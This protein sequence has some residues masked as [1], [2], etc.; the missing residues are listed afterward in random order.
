MTLGAAKQE[1]QWFTA[2]YVT[3][4]LLQNAEQ[5]KPTQ[6][7]VTAYLKEVS[8]T[9]FSSGEGYLTHKLEPL[10]RVHLHSKLD[11]LEPS[12][13]IT[14]IYVL[15]IIALLILF[16]AGVNYANLATAMSATRGTEVGIR[17]VLGANRRQLRMRF[18]GESFILTLISLLIG[19]IAAML[20]LPA[21]NNVAGTAIPLAGL[22]SPQAIGFMILLVLSISLLAGA[23]PAF[24]LSG[25]KMNE[26]LKSGI[27]I[28]AS[29]GVLRKGMIV[30][31]FVIAVFLIVATIIV[32]SQLNYIQNKELGYDKES[33]MILPADFRAGAGFE[34]MKMALLQIPGINSVTGAYESPSFVQ[35]SDGLHANTSMG[36]KNISIN[37]IPAELDFTKTLNMQLLAGRDFIKA[38]LLEMDTSNNGANYKASFILNESAAKAMGWSPE[39][40]IGKTVDR[41]V[42][43]TVKGVVKDFHFASLH[44]PIGP[45]V[46]FLDPNMVQQIFV[47][48]NHAG[49]PQTI[50][51]MEKVW[52]ARIQHRPFEYRFLDEDFAELYVTE[53]KTAQ[54]FSLFAG[55][56]ILLACLGLF[57]LSAF[58]TV[59][60]TKEI[61]IRKVLGATRSQIVMLLSREFLVLVSIGM[62]IA[63]PLAWWAGREW[64]ND[65]AYRTNI[66]SWMFLLATV[67]ATAIAFV[68][69]ALQSARA[70]GANPVNSLKN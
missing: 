39:Q 19:I 17:K 58:V 18:L 62:L 14:Y 8:K 32:T 7:Q 41:G 56:A 51:A 53:Q 46:I 12:G 29:G 42:S 28:S 61:G 16:I 13:S 40:A 55:M 67:V 50:A 33:V 49:M 10:T 25:N 11:G 1:E 64:L 47:K 59:Q 36:E 54:V 27:R 9:I 43:G 60:R 63:M 31:Q 6:T 3:Y 35:W 20:L 15:G 21:F 66:G 5:I 4:L 34:E 70:A 44:Q 52:K 37:A 48:V 2:N 45:L 26:V 57:A 30:L 22:F 23:Y 38:D 68:S 69:V 65:F 24:I